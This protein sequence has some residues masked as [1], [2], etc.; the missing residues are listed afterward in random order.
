MDPSPFHEKDLDHDLEE[1]MVSWAKEYP[2]HESLRWSCICKNA[3]PD[4]DPQTIIEGA[5]H[6]YFAYKTGLN[7]REFK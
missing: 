2:L 5:V 4:T 7:Q 6:N 3:P 1:F